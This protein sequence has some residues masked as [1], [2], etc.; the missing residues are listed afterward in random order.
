MDHSIS[1]R[2]LDLSKK[3]NNLS[4]S[5]FCLSSRS[6]SENERKQKDKQIL[7]CCQWTEKAVEHENDGNVNN[8]GR[9]KTSPQGLGKETSTVENQKKNWDHI[10]H[11]IVEIGE[12]TQSSEEIRWLAVNKKWL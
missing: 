5:E 12:N 4:S 1:N 8:T 10:D 3:R 9:V 6:L 2:R 7:G 11:S